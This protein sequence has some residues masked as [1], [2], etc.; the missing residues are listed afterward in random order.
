MKFGQENIG[1]SN[2]MCVLFPSMGTV[3]QKSWVLTIA[4]ILVILVKT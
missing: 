3:T 2:N 4:L 1:I